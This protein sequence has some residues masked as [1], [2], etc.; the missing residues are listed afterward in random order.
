MYKLDLIC[1]KDELRL[2]INYVLV[3]K[4]KCVATDA[5]VLGVVP[6]PLMFDEDFIDAIPENGVMI[7]REDWKKM[8]TAEFVSWDKDAIGKTIVLIHKKKR[9]EYIKVEDWTPTKEHPNPLKWPDWE[10]VIPD[11]KM[12]AETSVIGVNTQL[13]ATLSK[14][15]GFEASKLRFNGQSKA[16]TVTEAL[17]Y[18]EVDKGIYGICMPV[19]L[20]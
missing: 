10:R 8:S 4:E 17:G 3:T 18:N 9:D 20:H 16:I 5:N 11:E 13:L 7:H 14:A 2:N 6:T 12:E 1:S 19:R 15:L